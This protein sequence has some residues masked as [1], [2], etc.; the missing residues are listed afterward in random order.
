MYDPRPKEESQAASYTQASE[1]NASASS[2]NGREPQ[3]ILRLRFLLNDIDSQSRPELSGTWYLSRQRQSSHVR[4]L[5]ESNGEAGR[6]VAE[7]RV[8][9]L[10]RDGFYL[11]GCKDGSQYRTGHQ[12]RDSRVDG[13]NTRQVLGATQRASGEPRVSRRH[14]L[15]ERGTGLCVHREAGRIDTRMAELPLRQRDADMVEEGTVHYQ[16]SNACRDTTSAAKENV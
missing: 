1:P 11:D 12:G 2:S 4:Y 16:A 3:G 10:L 7:S 9:E 8:D 5:H 6:E 13:S 15:P 14:L